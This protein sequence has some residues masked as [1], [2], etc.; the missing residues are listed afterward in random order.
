MFTD[1]LPL[2]IVSFQFFLVPQIVKNAVGRIRGS[3]S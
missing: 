1:F 2:I 3:T